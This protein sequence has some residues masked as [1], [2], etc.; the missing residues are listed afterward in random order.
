MRWQLASGTD[1]AH[2][3]I[4]RDRG[5]TS[6][7]AA[8]DATGTSGAPN[9]DLPAGVLFWRAHGESGGIIGRQVGPTWQFTVG[10][11]SAQ[12]D[13]AWGTT[14]DL[15]GDGHPDAVIG[16]SL[17]DS[18][19]GRVSV[20]YGAGT[21]IGT[22]PGL[23]LSGPDGGGFGYAVASAGDV[24]GDGYGDLIVGTYLAGAPSGHAY[25]YLGGANGLGSMPA[26]TLLSKTPYFGG[27]VA[28]AGDVN[29]DGYADVVVGEDGG[30][31]STVAALFLGG[32]SGLSTTP[33]VTL[34]GATAVCAHEDYCGPEAVSLVAGAGDVN[35]DGYGD[36]II[37]DSGGAFLFSGSAAGPAGEPSTRLAGPFGTSL[38]SAGDVNGDGYADAIV[39]KIAAVGGIGTASL[40]LGSANGLAPSPDLTLSAGSSFG[41][42]VAGVGDVNGD[43]YG[44]VVVGDTGD[45][46]DFG[47]VYLFFG[48]ANGLSTSPDGLV[49]CPDDPALLAGWGFAQSVAGAGDANGDGY[50]DLLV[51]DPGSNS[52]AGAAFLFLGGA[53]GLETSPAT[54]WLSPDA[55]LA[56][57]GIS[58]ASVGALGPLSPARD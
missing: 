12:I 4:C 50:A 46:S 31:T 56:D 15:N 28:A 47:I 18:E 43:G 39:G 24:N 13:T 57:F 19:Q 37:S 5:C 53:A 54:T 48:G 27:S 21:E 36:V 26:A 49:Y 3:Q 32:P 11:S 55:G 41:S 52:N 25:L 58:V 17:V 44:D 7:V 33:A 2:V 42:S 35:G 38:A 6:E 10:K 45:N 22:T 16:E 20:Y 8:F 40:Y 30:P 23:V 14:L 51:G 1:G 9:S 34:V 29:G